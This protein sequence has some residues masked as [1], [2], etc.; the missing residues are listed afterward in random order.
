MQQQKLEKAKQLKLAQF[1]REATERDALMQKQVK[2]QL[3]NMNQSQQ[4]I[5]KNN[6]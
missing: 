5:S 6:N 1:I 4:I 3:I 2:N